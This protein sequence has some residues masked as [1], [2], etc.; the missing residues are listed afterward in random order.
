MLTAGKR[1]IIHTL[2]TGSS[3]IMGV[4]WWLNDAVKDQ[5]AAECQRIMIKT[6]ELRAEVT[7]LMNCMART[8]ENI[9]IM[10][11][12]IR[13]CQMVDQEAVAWMRGLP[14]HWHYTTVAW[15]DQ[16][17]QGNYARAEVYPGRVD[18]YADFYIASVWNMTRTARL[19]LASLIVRSAAWVC[20]PV[21][22]RTTPEYATAS[23]TCVETIT[24]IIAS[25]PYHLGWHLARP[26][27]LQRANLSHFA[28]GDEDASKSLAGYFLT[29][30]LSCIMGQ[31][32]TTD[33]QR[34]WCV[35]RLRY[36]ADQLGVKYA[37]ILAD[38]S[39]ERDEDVMMRDA[40]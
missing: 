17:P 15:E 13:R 33:N 1:Q 2:T 10:L 22:F 5:S 40:P 23:R 26:H 3:P 29:W 18:V 36:I 14:A 34:A 31:D 38:V 28:C 24:D 20:S 21:D 9:E 12:V 32:Y 19:I 35:G 4:E 37:H 16:V 6:G 39:L 7:R 30:P 25:V 27:L 11:N 8:P